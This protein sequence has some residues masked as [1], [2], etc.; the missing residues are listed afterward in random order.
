MPGPE[1]APISPAGDACTCFPDEL[2][3]AIARTKLETLGISLDA[4]SDA[5][6]R[7][8]SSWQ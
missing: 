3:D 1:S 7:F 6:R 5:Q 4:A 2:D 8:K